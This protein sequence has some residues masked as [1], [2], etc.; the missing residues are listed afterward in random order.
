MNY[1]YVGVGGMAGSVLRYTISLYT[2]GVWSGSFPFGTLI[3]NICGCFF[4]GWMT[5]LNEKKEFIP[6]YIML[7]IGTGTIGSMTT[8][9]TF[10]VE[11]F[12][13]YESGAIFAAGLYVLLSAGMGLF[14][15]WTG[16]SIGRK[17][18]GEEVKES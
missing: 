13:L 8:F 9:S 2:A 3:V 4:L 18:R 16:F 17:N 10:S 14:L 1:L 11:T 15:A 12:Q 6:K 5:G 7:G